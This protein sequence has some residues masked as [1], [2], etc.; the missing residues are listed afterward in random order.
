MVTKD[1][2]KAVLAEK[3]D[4]FRIFEVKF[5]NPPSYDEIGVKALYERVV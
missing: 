1:F 5:C 4:L 3:K 2:F